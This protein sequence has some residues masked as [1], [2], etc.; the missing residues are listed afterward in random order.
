M[1]NVT[2]FFTMP[3]YPSVVRSTL[4][5]IN[6]EVVIPAPYQA[7]GELQRESSSEILDSLVS[8]TGQA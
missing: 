3:L 4:L 6:Q 5:C 2:I 8:S 7:R 1:G